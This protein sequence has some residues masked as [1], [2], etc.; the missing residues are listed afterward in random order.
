MKIIKFS[1]IILSILLYQKVAYSKTVLY[2]L[3]ISKCEKYISQIEQNK[4]FKYTYTIWAEGYMSG[5]NSA[6]YQL[7]KK[8]VKD[9]ELDPDYILSYMDNF[10]LKNPF[11]P[12]FIGVSVL[13]NSLPY[14]K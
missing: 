7:Q 8:N 4:V 2:G 3:G 14:Y 5:L 12:Y 1:V 10:C 13:Y 6:I 11:K 9:V